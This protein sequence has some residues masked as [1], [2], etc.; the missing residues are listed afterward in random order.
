[1]NLNVIRATLLLL[2]LLAKQGFAQEVK[3]NVLSNDPEKHNNF[4]IGASLFPNIDAWTGVDLLTAFGANI[5]GTYRF[6]PGSI[7]YTHEFRGGDDAFTHQTLTGT[8]AL[9]N[10]VIDNVTR[11][12]LNYSFNTNNYSTSY[13]EVPSKSLETFEI[14]GGFDRMNPILQYGEKDEDGDLIF[15]HDLPVQITSFHGG[16]QYAIT[17]N[18]HIT[19]DGY[20]KKKNKQQL[21]WYADILYAFRM[22]IADADMAA[23]EAVRNDNLSEINYSRIGFRTGFKWWSLTNIGW[24]VGVEYGWRPTV[25]PAENST[26]SRFHLGL[27]LTAPIVSFRLPYFG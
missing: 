20:G 10:R 4:S 9:V 18:I 2:L 7:R 14:R 17:D 12:D 26:W 11:V 3:Y 22:N 1:M 23:F 19:T 25:R 6:G 8:F 16:I 24:G 27:R 5:E 15:E 21:L 13:I